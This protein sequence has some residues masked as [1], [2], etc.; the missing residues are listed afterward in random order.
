[1]PI[2][3][4]VRG[5]FG[6][7]GRLGAKFG[8]TGG[9]IT[10]AGGYRI[11]TF[12]LAESATNLTFSGGAGTVE[13]LILAGGGGGGA[14]GG[15]DGS[16]GGGAGGLLTGS[17]AVLSTNYSIV[18]GPGAASFPNGAGTHN[19]ASYNGGNSTA[20]SLTAF[21]G[22]SASSESGVSRQAQNG[23]CGGGAGGYSG[24]FGTG[25][26]GPPRQGYDGGA[27]T[28]PGDGGGGGTSAPGASGSTRTGGAG[29]ASSISGTSV[30]YGGGGGA[31]G[32]PRIGGG[33]GGAGGA[34]G[35]GRGMNVN[36]GDSP[37]S[38]TNGLG[39]GGG[40]AA[41]STASG[42]LRGTGAGGNGIVIIRY[43]L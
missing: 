9:I 27:A 24:G 3:S 10:V 18:V 42:V 1:M 4:T 2:V 43:Q 38:G 37:V 13:Y 26:A 41:G 33:N 5:S 7:Q 36:S 40:G 39:G 25:F 6:A 12:T 19:P 23:G 29:T 16:G 21:G 30:T 32:D 34:G 8:S 35:G 17:V 14:A 31:S 11:H 20:F 28:G 15:T 22:G